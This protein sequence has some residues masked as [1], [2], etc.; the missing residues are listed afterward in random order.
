[1][2]CLLPADGLSSYFDVQEDPGIVF[3]CH[4]CLTTERSPASK[5]VVCMGDF[6]RCPVNSWHKNEWANCRVVKTV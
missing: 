6:W 3:S 4:R 5:K 1:M 2:G